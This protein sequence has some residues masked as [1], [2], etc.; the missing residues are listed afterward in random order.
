MREWLADPRGKQV[1]GPLYE[2]IETQS[3]KTFGEAER[4]GNEKAGDKSVM[5]MDIMDMML[6]MPLVSVLMFLQ[7]SFTMPAEEIVDGLLTQVH[8][9]MNI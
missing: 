2:K 1:L 4:Y 7:G 3:R 9:D 8:N 6:D 5:G